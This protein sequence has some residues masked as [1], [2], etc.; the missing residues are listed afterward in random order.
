AA[1]DE[2]VPVGG[3]EVE[4]KPSIGGG[5]KVFRGEPR[6]DFRADL[7][8]AGA[9]RGAQPRADV[10]GPLAECAQRVDGGARGSLSRPAPAR[11]R[12][13]DRLLAGKENR[14]AVG[15]LNGD[16][17]AGKGGREDVAGARVAHPPGR[18]LPNDADFSAM[19]LRGSH[20]RRAVELERVREATRQIG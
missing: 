7:V 3:C 13:G 1:G 8:A 6:G 19:D 15:R 10:F 16:G 2:L 9:D 17:D 11:V 12:G 5:T 4:K 18:R 20:D 14:N